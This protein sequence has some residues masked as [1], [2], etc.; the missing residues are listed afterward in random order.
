MAQKGEVNK[1]ALALITFFL[2]GIGGHKFYLHKYWQGVFYLL[3]CWT[4][5]PGIIALIE[6][7]I[8]LCTSEEDLQEKYPDAGGIGAVIGILA[9]IVGL[10]VLI[11]ILAAI[12]L[13]AYQA[14][15]GKSIQYQQ[16]N[17]IFAAEKEYFAEHNRYAAQLNELNLQMPPNENITVEITGADEKC[18]EAV[19]HHRNLPHSIVVDCDKMIKKQP[20]N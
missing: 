10:I 17:N 5:I 15:I 14:Y 4:G 19:I 13:P 18:F 6:F 9:G 3:F 11:G 12:M 8:Y 7:I 1:I 20:R 2:G 16:M